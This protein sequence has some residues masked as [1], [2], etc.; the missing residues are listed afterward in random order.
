M[1]WILY[2]GGGAKILIDS[3]AF[4]KPPEPEEIFG[5]FPEKPAD[6]KRTITATYHGPM[7]HCKCCGS[8][9]RIGAYKISINGC[10]DEK[11]IL[12]CKKCFGWFED[13]VREAGRRKRA[14]I[15]K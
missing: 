12:L 10:R 7:L 13:M 14:V 6:L 3:S 4:S 9:E 5:D 15:H 11:V 1:S 2:V 8:T